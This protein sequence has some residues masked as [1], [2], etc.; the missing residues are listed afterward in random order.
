MYDTIL[1]PH[2]GTQTGDE[3]LRHAIHIA[4]LDSSKI[5]ILHVLY[6]WYDQAFGTMPK[7]EKSINKQIDEIFSHM[8]E[9][10]QVFLS[11]CVERCRKEGVVCE[12]IFRTGK[13]SDSIIKYTQN[14]KIDLIIMGKKRKL[15]NY[16]SLFKI[17]SVAKKV[18]E[19]VKCPILLVEVD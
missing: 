2:G 8:K 12:G 7:G 10:V 1:V 14:E 11:E 15:P 13:P 3:A 6:T 5:I 16:Q 18:Q 19:K 17:G 4:K 9:N